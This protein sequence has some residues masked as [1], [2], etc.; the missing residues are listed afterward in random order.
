M[1]H[2]KMIFWLG[3][4]E[5]R[6]LKYDKVMVIFVIYAFTL[7]IYSQATGT[8]SEIHNASVAVVDDDRSNLSAHLMDALYPPRFLPPE[9]IAATEVDRA[10]DQGKYIFVIEIPPRF[11]L[12][13]RAGRTPEIQLSI[14]ATAMLQAGVGSS[15]IQKIILQETQRFLKRSDDSAAQPVAV[16]TRRLF[17]PN[18][19]TS[20]FNS[21]VAIV[22]QITLLT[23]VLTGAALL[24]E[25]E[26]GTIEHLLVMPL[27]AFDIA[28]AKVWANGLVILAAATVSL[29]LIVKGVLRVP[30]AGSEALF[31]L[32]VVLY[33]FFATALGV[34]LGTITRTMAQFAMLVVVLVIML[35]L[36][37][38]G[39]TPIESQPAWLQRFTWYLPSA[40]FVSFAQAIIY[41]GAGWS[42]VW[43]DFALVAV[44]GVLCMAYS[45]S[46]F[47][48]MIA[49]SK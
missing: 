13:A 49:A 25:R 31:L 30:V 3:T 23:I 1:Q 4:K 22:N 39:N 45:L 48:K 35:Q 32:G 24:R 19:E 43:R 34:L 44:M 38:G 28:M 14:D 41:R 26:Q 37:S 7:A 2:L 16:V 8:S 33:L 6:S 29:L 5:L 47:R 18:G 17:N 36:L 12:D 11:E 27:T 46:R 20:W 10:L 21:I 40:R 9:R 42:V 15:Y